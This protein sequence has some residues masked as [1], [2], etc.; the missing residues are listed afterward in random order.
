[1]KIRNGFVSN[2][3]SSSFILSLKDLTN[4]QKEKINEFFIKNNKAFENDF[5]IITAY[6]AISQGDVETHNGPWNKE[7][8]E[9]EKTTFEEIFVKL[10]NDIGIDTKNEKIFRIKYGDCPDTEGMDV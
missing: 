2:S 5:N 7:K 9:Y 10:L 1:M 3:S 8:H 4:E 6:D